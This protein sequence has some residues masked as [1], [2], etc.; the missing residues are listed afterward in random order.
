M[1]L[2]YSISNLSLNVRCDTS[3]LCWCA[4]FLKDVCS[5]ESDVSS[6]FTES[7]GGTDGFGGKSIPVASIRKCVDVLIVRIIM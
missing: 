7:R 1:K 4:V 5:F 6:Y 2:E 3:Q